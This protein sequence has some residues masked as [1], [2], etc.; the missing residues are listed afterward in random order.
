MSY[1]DMNQ[2]DE[3]PHVGDFCKVLNKF[4]NYSMWL[5]IKYAISFG[6]NQN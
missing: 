2:N 4:L 1:T 3:N 6:I 5:L